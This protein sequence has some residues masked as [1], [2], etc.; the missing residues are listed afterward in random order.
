MKLNTEDLLAG[1]KHY[2]DQDGDS[3]TWSNQNIPINKG[4]ISMLLV[5]GF[6]LFSVTLYSVNQMFSESFLARTTL[7]KVGV[8]GFFFV[9][10]LL[11]IGIALEFLNRKRLEMIKI[12]DDEIIVRRSWWISQK[13]KRFK[14]QGLDR[15]VIALSFLRYGSGLSR[16]SSNPM[17]EEGG[18]GQPSLNIIYADSMRGASGRNR[19]ILAHWMRPEEKFQLFLMLKS[20]L[21]NRGWEIDFHAESIPQ[22]FTN[23][24]PEK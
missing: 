17:L 21:Q 7:E 23:T 2:H 4:Y 18:E 9:L 6:V 19:E 11:D 13:T 16:A 1:V 5:F 14:R 24:F 22:S 8:L 10:V 3:F 15:G 12:T 20:V